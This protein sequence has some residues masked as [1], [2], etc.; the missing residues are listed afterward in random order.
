M[1]SAC[2]RVPSSPIFFTFILVVEEQTSWI[3]FCILIVFKMAELQKVQHKIKEGSISKELEDSLLGVDS[4]N[5]PG[6]TSTGSSTS[7]PSS[8]ALQLI[9][10]KLENMQGRLASLERGSV[11]NSS[12]A[13]SREAVTAEISNDQEGDQDRLWD[14]HSTHHLSTEE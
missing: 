2:S 5:T 10:S 1:Y 14:R 3:Q 9:L 12:S 13:T 8:D 11:N 4:S 6:A 7:S